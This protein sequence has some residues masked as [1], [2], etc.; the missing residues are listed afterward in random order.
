MTDKIEKFLSSASLAALKFFIDSADGK[1]TL[2]CGLHPL[3]E[4][5][6]KKFVSTAKR[7]GDKVST[8][9]LVRHL[10]E[11][12]WDEELARELASKYESAFSR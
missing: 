4:V 7:N 10:M 9:V 11:N 8:N 1:N 3:D 2:K 6:W 5:R 12:G